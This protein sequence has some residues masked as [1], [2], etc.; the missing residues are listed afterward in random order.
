MSRPS[1]AASGGV[2]E[3][4]PERA[5]DEYRISPVS[6]SVRGP[7][8]LRFPGS[9]FAE[10]SLPSLA[11]DVL[12]VASLADS[13]AHG[14]ASLGIPRRF[15]RDAALD[16]E[17]GVVSFTVTGVRSYSDTHVSMRAHGGERDLGS[18]LLWLVTGQSA[19]ASPAAD[20]VAR[21]ASALHAAAS[22]KQERQRAVA[23]REVHAADERRLR[24]RQ[25]LQE[26]WDT[27]VRF[28]R[29]AMARRA[30]LIA[31]VSDDARAAYT[32]QLQAM[33]LRPLTMTP[34]R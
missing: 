25:R 17:T 32:A 23:A 15:V 19:H 26:R 10:V 3:P 27:L 22:L 18:K 31:P 5:C 21:A 7:L 24:A 13:A 14:E 11:A 20:L 9:E 8:G 6:V 16:R 1:P 34:P 28:E 33:L 12:V 29:D 2:R 30:E 4:S